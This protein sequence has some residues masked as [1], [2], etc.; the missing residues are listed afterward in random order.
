MIAQQPEEHSPEVAHVKTGFA[1]SLHGQLGT[2]PLEREF[3][4]T[5]KYLARLN[6]QENAGC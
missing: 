3:S 6:P 1:Q 2:K 5:P 4:N